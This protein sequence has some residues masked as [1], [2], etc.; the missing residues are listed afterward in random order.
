[1]KMVNTSTQIHITDIKPYVKFLPAT[2][3]GLADGFMCSRN[4]CDRENIETNL[5]FCW[6]SCYDK[7]DKKQLL[8]LTNEFF[9]KMLA[10]IFSILTK[11]WRNLLMY[12]Y[13]RN[14]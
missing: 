1:M 10:K 7:M 9:E 4:S 3:D 11:N 2:I 5:P 14:S 13:L 8:G 12:I 6:M